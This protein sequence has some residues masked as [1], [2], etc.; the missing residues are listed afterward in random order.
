MRSLW[1]ANLLTPDGWVRRARVTIAHGRVVTVA[2]ADTP[3][4]DDERVTVGVPGLPDVHSH[5]F[6]RGMA[7]RAERAGP[8]ADSFWTWRQTM[9]R[10]AGAV[11]PDHAEAI[12]MLLYTE[13]LEAGFTRVGEF[14]Y[15]HHVSE[16]KPYASLDEMAQ[17]VVSAARASGIGLTLLHCLY[18]YA[19][20]GGAPAHAGQARF[21][22]TPEQFARLMEAAQALPRHHPGVVVGVA[23]HSLRAVDPAGLREA[24]A[25][26]GD[27][28]IHIHV[29]EQRREV[30]A[31][32]AW[33]GARPVA[34]LLD[35]A[36]VDARWC[37]IHATHSE[38]AEYAGI[39]ARGAVVGL[40]PVTE[41]SLGDGVF[42]A[43]GF[44]AAQG[45]LAMGTDSNISIGAAS[46]LRQLEYSQRLRDGTRN[47]LAPPGRSTGR[48]L[49]DTAV[50]GGAR[51]LGAG[52]AGITPGAW[53]DIVAL[54]TEHP[55]LVAAQDDAWLDAWIFSAGNAAVDRV[56][57][58]GVKLVQGGRHVARER[59]RGAY[60]QA[61]R[62]LWES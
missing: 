22:S 39:A 58:R 62:A 31:C 51:A 41:A 4:A 34:W 2:P 17:R 23:P 24:V 32:L 27:G 13:L 18:R 12:A 16:G 35:N 14:H 52:P 11:Q 3:D 43:T 20:F 38:A 28:P 15:L 1:F 50:A 40:C 57:A 7:G 10:F 25:L 49:L 42:P 55:S 6:Q 56:W 36:P 29:A 8:T 59:A 19:D 46:E 60:A 33:S 44:L 21:V 26:A 47:A 54:D 45:R 30:E 48:I 53:A 61:M 5:A 9:Y 37:L